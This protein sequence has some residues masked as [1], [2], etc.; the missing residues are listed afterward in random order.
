[1]PLKHLSLSLLAFL[2]YWEKVILVSCSEKENQ[3]MRNSLPPQPVRIHIVLKAPK[4]SLIL[5]RSPGSSMCET[6]DPAIR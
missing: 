5:N 1:M 2:Q 4:Q 6:A 3:P